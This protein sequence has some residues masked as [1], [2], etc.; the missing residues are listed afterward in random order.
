MLLS[1]SSKVEEKMLTPYLERGK[2][3]LLLPCGS[4][5]LQTILMMEKEK[6]EGTQ[7]PLV[8]QSLVFALW[9]QTVPLFPPLKDKEESRQL[10]IAKE[11]M[12]HVKENYAEDLSLESIAK[13][14][15]VST[16]QASKLFRHYFYQSP[17]SYLISYRLSQAA[18]MLKDT[19]KTVE[20]I[21]FETGYSSPSFFIRSFKK[22]YGATPKA[23]QQKAR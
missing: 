7:N 8:Y 15:H 2:S 18:S 16:S 17:V 11:M 21:A 20:E 23:Y 1:S 22:K 4:K 14:G 5:A 19:D 9:S 12:K 6:N 3:Y 10:V 13:V